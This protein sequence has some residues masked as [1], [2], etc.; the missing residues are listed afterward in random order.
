LLKVLGGIIKEEINV[1]AIVKKGVEFIVIIKK[2]C[3]V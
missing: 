3:T 1:E 2:V